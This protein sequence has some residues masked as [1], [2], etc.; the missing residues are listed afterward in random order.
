MEYNILQKNLGLLSLPG[1]FLHTDRL[2]I[3]MTK[4]EQFTGRA[5]HE[6]L[7]SLPT[8]HASMWYKR[9]P[10]CR[11]M[12]SHS[13]EVVQFAN[14]SVMCQIVYGMWGADKI[15]FV[16]DDAQ[17]Y[18]EYRLADAEWRDRLA[19]VQ[20]D[21]K[22]RGNLP[23]DY[24]EVGEHEHMSL[25]AHQ[26]TMAY[27]AHQAKSYAYFAKQG[28]GKTA[29]AIAVL[30]KLAMEKEETV[31]A[32]IVCPKNVCFN[33]RCELD[34]FLPEGIEYSLKIIKGGKLKRMQCVAELFA[35]KVHLRVA[36]INYEGIESTWQVFRN[37]N[38]DICIAD[39]SHE[40]RNL[41]T[42]RSKYMHELGRRCEIRI[43]MTGTPIANNV[44]DLYSQLEW[45]E[46]GSH[47]F[48]NFNA[49]KKFYAKM[50]SSNDRNGYEKFMAVQN[51]PILK[52]VLSRYSFTITKEEALPHLPKKVYNAQSVPLSQEQNDIY[53][54][55][56]QSLAY[57]LRDELDASN[58]KEMTINNIL[59]QLLRLAQVSAG[60]WVM[61]GESAVEDRIRHIQDVPKIDALFDII[62]NTEQNE[63]VIVWSVFVPSVLRLKYECEKRKLNYVLYY[64]GVK[65]EDRMTAIERF[66]TDPS[67]KV[68]LGNPLAGSAG[69]NLLGYNYKD[70]EDQWLDTNC[71]KTI[72]YSSNW[73]TVVREQSEDRSHRDG[74]RQQIE[75]I[76]L[77][78]EGTIDEEIRQ[79]VFTKRDAA[80]GVADIRDILEG[81]MGM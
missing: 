23:A 51:L 58:N 80:M 39:E 30:S 16:D 15:D 77:C 8:Y 47:G 64:G 3:G 37:I 10:H 4:D 28:T 22:L 5:V 6:D 67:V 79:R 52:E 61:D 41:R 26:R 11:I 44:L 38:W 14:T 25:R 71:T 75:C 7:V 59:T 72:Y 50:D 46:P 29:P 62:D 12:Q 54:S 48:E 9:L 81:V 27:I 19:A 56:A 35:K 45:I 18:F 70:P 40:F 13:G 1:E 2:R 17:Q 34:R 76:D 32:I 57:K 66:N 53:T 63:K 31:N 74:T 73:S 65:H 55:L 43:P 60:Y 49:F 69:V 36:I 42:N 24:S 21:F 68:F 78:G 33:W 20:A